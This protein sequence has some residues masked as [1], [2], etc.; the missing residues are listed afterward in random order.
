MKKTLSLVF[1]LLLFNLNSCMYSHITKDYYDAYGDKCHEET[2]INVSFR[3][4]EKK[5]S[6]NKGERTGNLNL[7]VNKPQHDPQSNQ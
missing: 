5:V 7:N 3:T 6:C 1:T 4:E 2:T